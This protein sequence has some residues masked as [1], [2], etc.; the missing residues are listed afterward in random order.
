MPVRCGN[1]RGAARAGREAYFRRG[2]IQRVPNTARRKGT[3]V[4][5]PVHA[6]LRPMFQDIARDHELRPKRYPLFLTKPPMEPSAEE[7][8]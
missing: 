1:M 7:H 6:S 3:A 5:V 2:S 8:G 4:V